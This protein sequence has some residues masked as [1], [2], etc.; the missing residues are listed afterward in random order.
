MFVTLFALFL[1]KRLCLVA[2]LLENCYSR[3]RETFGIGLEGK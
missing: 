1:C 3:R 2:K